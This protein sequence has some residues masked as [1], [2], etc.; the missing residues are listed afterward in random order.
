VLLAV[1]EEL[2]SGPL[3]AEP[4]CVLLHGDLHHGNVLASAR[5]G[6]VAIDPKGV[7]GE[8]AYEV[9]GAVY[10]G[11]YSLA[12]SPPLLQ[13]RLNRRLD[14]FAQMLGV[15]RARLQAWAFV[16]A[17]LSAFWMHRAGDPRWEGTLA[18]AAALHPPGGTAA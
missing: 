12:A 16:K 2:L 14:P 18:C 9:A 17:L 1:A 6:W 8:P 5:E 11:L 3:A 10:S 4:S 13:R 7:P 15:D